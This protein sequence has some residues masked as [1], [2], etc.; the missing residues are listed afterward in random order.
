MREL[1][2]ELVLG[3]SGVAR[4]AQQAKS[5]MAGLQSYFRMTGKSLTSLIGT[6]SVRAGVAVA[7]QLGSKISPLADMIGPLSKAQSK[8]LGKLIAQK[9][10][11][12]KLTRLHANTEAALTKEMAKQAQHW[13]ANPPPVIP[14]GIRALFAKL[15]QGGIDPLLAT[16]AGYMGGGR[17]GGLG[18]AM[19]GMMGAPG[20][21]A[22]VGVAIGM[23]MGALRRMFDF[24][25]SGFMDLIQLANNLQAMKAMTGIGYRTG[26]VISRAAE[27]GGLDPQ[28]V[29]IWFSRF[30][31]NMGI[32]EKTGA[33]VSGALTLMGLSIGQIRQLKPDEQFNLIV[34]SLAKVKGDIDQN[35]IA[36]TLFNRQGAQMRKEVLNTALAIEQVGN[37]GKNLDRVAWRDA[38]GRAVTYA[39]ALAYLDKTISGL[40]WKKMDFI[41][42]FLGITPESGGGPLKTTTGIAGM[43]N[44][45]DAGKIGE[46]AMKGVKLGFA[47]LTQGISL[48]PGM[49]KLADLVM[50]KAGILQPSNIPIAGLAGTSGGLGPLSSFFAPFGKGPGDQWSK[51]G[52]FSAPGMREGFATGIQGWRDKVVDRLTQIAQNTRTPHTAAAWTY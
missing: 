32:V 8:E 41:R 19:G 44:R 51:I 38:A 26:A 28:A 11:I 45:A 25:K 14:T 33:K 17:M 24:L 36:M 3:A 30:Q 29:S 50:T 13:K 4:G 40:R 12:L 16:A 2:A 23:I 20:I 49:G 35:A 10:E 47:S 15:T 42:G 48:I 31:A 22:A 52:A 1:R 34:T 18:G 43:I 6:D 27:M 5:I 46:Y 9:A 37:L 7:K 39:D 21:G